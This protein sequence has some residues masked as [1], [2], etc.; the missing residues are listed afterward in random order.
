MPTENNVSLGNRSSRSGHPLFWVFSFILCLSLLPKKSWAATTLPAKKAPA[1]QESTLMLR[2]KAEQELSLEP[3]RNKIKER[4]SHT[5][6]LQV[7]NLPTPPSIVS[8]TYT[9]AAIAL[10][11]ISPGGS[12]SMIGKQTYDLSQVSKIPVVSAQI[13]RWIIRDFERG[14]QVGIL[15][16]TS[17]GEKAINLQHTNGYTL[18]NVEILYM[19]LHAGLGLQKTLIEDRLHFGLTGSVVEELWQQNASS[20]DARWSRWNPALALNAQ[21]KF[22]I[23]GHWY[24]LLEFHKQWPL[25]ENPIASEMERWHLGLG[26][27]L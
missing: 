16:G 1:A 20:I 4:S 13:Q 19:R 15:F 8:P 14:H 27:Y 26:Y 18:S 10:S 2:S 5:A 11:T 17:V 6:P 21:T 12:A 23:T 22:Q 25:V 24:S 9:E 3:L 7:S